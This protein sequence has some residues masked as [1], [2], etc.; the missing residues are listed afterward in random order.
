MLVS[1]HI[2]DTS[3]RTAVRLFVSPPKPASTPG[4]RR[5][6]VGFAAPLG[7]SLFP[8]PSLRRI[9]VVAFWDDESALETF[10][11]EHPAAAW[12]DGG[13]RARLTP[14]RAH[15]HW[16]G[17]DED[18]PSER[19]VDHDGPAVV[20]TLGRLRL[21]QAMRFLRT[22]ARAEAAV[23]EAP[24]LI[25]TTG[26]GRPPFVGTCS[27]WESSAALATYAYGRGQPAHPEAI[28][29]GNRKLFHKEQVFA[30]F[31]AHGVTGHLDGRNPIPE[32][33]LAAS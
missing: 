22:S 23:A 17:L 32:D 13:W 27:V 24:G 15:G 11:A 7:G 21:T 8:S 14:L 26:L 12:M 31:R 1:L 3:L 16:R 18:V 28:T 4:L 5:A 10:L 20:L 2:A 33:A 29:E 9:G 30:R 19:S 25:W 6:N